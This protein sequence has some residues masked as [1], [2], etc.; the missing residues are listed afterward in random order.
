MIRLPPGRGRLWSWALDPSLFAIL[1]KGKF[2]CEAAK[3]VI[4]PRGHHPYREIICCLLQQTTITTACNRARESTPRTSS[5]GVLKSAWSP[6]VQGPPRG[7]HRSPRLLLLSLL[8]CAKMSAS[9]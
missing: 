2:A 3:A 7:V 5:G 9:D 4:A 6:D 1:R 8:F